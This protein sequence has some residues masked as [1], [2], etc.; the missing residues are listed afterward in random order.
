MAPYKNAKLPPIPHP[1]KPG[2]RTTW[3]RSGE[4]FGQ[5]HHD[6]KDPREDADY[7]DTVRR[8]YA[9]CVTYADKH[10]GDML[11]TLKETGRDKNTIVVLW[12]DHGWHLGEHAVWGKHTLFEESLRSPLIIRKPGMQEPG[13]KSDAV[14]ETVD[15]FPTLCELAK[16]PAP[17]FAHG[18]SLNAQL[19]DPAAPGH[20]AYSYQGKATTIRT[21]SHR[22]TLH[23][24]GFIEL[25]DHRSDAKET[26]NVAEQNP[27]VCEEL[28]QLIGAKAVDQ[29]G[30]KN[31]KRGQKRGQERMALPLAE[32]VPA[33][34]AVLLTSM[35]DFEILSMSCE[36]FD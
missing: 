27:A 13:E 11:A 32:R 25:Y 24:D 7:A 16:I 8:H 2:W 23:K 18:I 35:S 20:N 26:E 15:V 9:A 5:Y 14:V 34:A 28:K 31:A 4:F 36:R 21:D 33:C 12:G 19:Q 29:K 17:E 10:V 3:H 22:M 30:Q 1:A 6:D